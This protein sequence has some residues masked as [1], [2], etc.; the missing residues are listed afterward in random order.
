MPLIPSYLSSQDRGAVE[1]VGNTDNDSLR[2]GEVLEIVYPKDARSLSGKFI[3]YTVAV[4]HRDGTGPE[5]TSTYTG[6][7]VG[8]MF[9]LGSDT[10]RYTLRPDTQTSSGDG[11][12]KDVV[13][14]GAKVLLLCV[15]GSKT[16]SVIV[17][18]IRDVA[19]GDE[20][21]EDTKEKGHNLY[22][23]FNGTSFEIDK[24][25]A[26]TVQFKGATDVMGEPMEGNDAAA[27][28][29]TLKINKD[30][31]FSITTKDDAQLIRIEHKDK[32]IR[33]KGD[34]KVVIECDHIHLGREDAADALAL[35]SKCMANYEKVVD[36]MGSMGSTFDGHKHEVD[37]IQ[38][39]GAP[40]KHSQTGPVQSAKPGSSAPGAPSMDEVASA[41]VLSE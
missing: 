14:I 11:K 22:F 33:I 16:R 8:N 23:E 25:G 20:G 10:L 37:N 7:I 3:E 21:A 4:S 34:A 24:D 19:T 18:G 15:N 39:A 1:N 2:V 29:T 26:T 31:D 9:G 12:K 5:V 17:G 32:K 30:G 13:G 27:Q 40:T 28:P 35:A 36:W 41:V 6:C 38:T